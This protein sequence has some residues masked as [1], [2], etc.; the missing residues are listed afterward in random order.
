MDVKDA[1]AALKLAFTDGGLA[2]EGTPMYNYF[3]VKSAIENHVH[4]G[5]VTVYKD[6]LLVTARAYC[7]ESRNYNDGDVVI[8]M[9]LGDPDLVDRLL[10]LFRGR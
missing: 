8:Q 2:V 6:D 1:V 7:H 4:A 5:V 10:E 3:M 9:P